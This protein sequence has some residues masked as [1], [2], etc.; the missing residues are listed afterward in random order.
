MRLTPCSLGLGLCVASFLSDP[1][2]S[3]Q[4]SRSTAAG[5]TTRSAAASGAQKSGARS[6]RGPLPD[7]V[8]LDGSTQPAEKK[9]E[10]GML[11]EFEIPGD[12]NARGGKVGGPQRPPEIAVSLPS[13]LGIPGLS[14][15]GLPGGTSGG[16]LE[17]PDPTKSG[18]AGAGA[19]GAEPLNKG[20]ADARG[21]SAGGGPPVAGNDA[22]AGGI[23][24]S[25]LKTD[26]SAGPGGQPGGP[27]LQVPKPQPIAIGDPTRQ[28][29]PA[30]NA[31]G[32][33]G[34]T[35]TAG[36]TQQMEKATGGGTGKSSAGDNG[37]RGVEKGRAMPA[38]L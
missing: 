14:G 15:G 4:D 24:V 32:V 17:L 29:K 10:Y 38:G 8:L 6:A 20:G 19:G 5:S 9:S 13:P 36:N 28:I 35:T 34:A 12:E 30:P 3:A 33:V 37:N 31:P 1:V 21:A 11:G 25:E 18:G 22:A 23:Q 27:D 2:V 26:P 16:G 7:P